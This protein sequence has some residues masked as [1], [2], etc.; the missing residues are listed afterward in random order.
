MAV[1]KSVKQ[2]VAD[3]VKWYHGMKT[4][5]D[6]AE[7]TFQDAKFEFGT[8]MDRYFDICANEDGKL[9]IEVE[10]VKNVKKVIV[11]KVQP[12]EVIWDVEKLKK[13]LSPKERK[14][15]INKQYMVIN[16][17]GL[18]DLLKDAGIDFKEFLKYVKVTE[19]VSVSQLDKL[20]DLGAVDEEEVKACS[21][22]KLK[23]SYYKLTEK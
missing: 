23:G 21:S 19:T 6:S 13:L 8:C 9:E 18:F 16:W 22:V 12:S 3:M 4:S 20:V 14:L 2:Y 7:R 1:K 5:H 11:T 17:R 15:V 10:D